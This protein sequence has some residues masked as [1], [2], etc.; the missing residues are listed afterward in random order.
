MNPGHT[1]APASRLAFPAV[2][3]FIMMNFDTDFLPRAIERARRVVPI[4][5]LPHG[6]FRG[7]AHGFPLSGQDF[8]KDFMKTLDCAFVR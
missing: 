6:L 2:P 4:L 5:L 8:L 7:A 1:D 3:R